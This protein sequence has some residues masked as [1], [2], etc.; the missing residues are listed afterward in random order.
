MFLD[1]CVTYLP[2][3]SCTDTTGQ[4]TKHPKAPVMGSPR[5][6][7]CSDECAS[8]SPTRYHTA[9]RT[10]P[11]RTMEFPSLQP[12]ATANGVKFMSTP[13][14]RHLGYEWE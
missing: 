5:D 10:A 11:G 3:C 8:E 1:T 14:I 2:G 9:Q 13:L 6:R 4:A 7:G 12:K